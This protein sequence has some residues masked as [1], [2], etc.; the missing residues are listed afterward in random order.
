MERGDVILDSIADGVFTVGSDWTIRS[1]N[2]AA[3]RITGIPR[4]QA[5][6]RQCWEVFRASICESACALRRTL[7][8]GRSSVN[9]VIYIVNSAGERVPISVSTALLRDEGRDFL[10]VHWKEDYY[11][12]RFVR[13][14]REFPDS[15]EILEGLAEG[16]SVVT[17]GTFL[18][19]SDVL[20]EKM[21]A[22]CAD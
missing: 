12:R 14:G 5:I 10:F 6:G 4:D 16:E 21:G 7:E 9:E 8:S 18:L 11:V 20:R 17:D 15:V 1:F 13:R 3:E 22:G 19:K 2:R